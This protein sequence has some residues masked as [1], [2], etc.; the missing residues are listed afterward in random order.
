MAVPKDAIPSLAECQC[1]ICTEIF[2]EPVTLP[3]NHTLCNPCFQSTVEKANLCCPFCRRRVSSWTRYHTRRKTLVNMELWETIQKHYPK[4]CKLRACGQESEEIVDDFQPVRV[5]SIPGELRR[6]YEEE[7][8]K[9]EAER[10]ANEEKE[11][12]ASEEYIQR[13]LAEEE[14]EEKRQAEKRQREME[15]QLKSDEELARRLSINISSVCERSVVASPLNSRKSNSVTVKSQK[16]SKNF[17]K[18]TGDIQKYLSPKSLF[19]SASQSEDKQSSISKEN[20]SGD[21]ASPL[22]P[23]TEIEE[24][25]PTLSPQI[26]PDIEE[27]DAASL[28]E[29][30]M[31]QLS[32][33]GSEWSTEGEVKTAL[34]NH[35]KELCV[36]NPE[37]PQTK[38]FRKT[39]VNHCGRTQSGLS[40]VTD[41]VTTTNS[42]VEAKNEETSLLN[43]IDTSKRKNQEPSSETVKDPCISPKR[44]KVFPKIS[45]DQEEAEINFTQKLIE[46]EQLLFERHKQE[47]QDRLLALQLQKEVDK[48]QMKPNRQKGS[49]DAYQLRTTTIYPD[50]LPNG[51]KNSK[52]KNF[53]KQ[54]DREHPQ[55]R[56]GSRDENCQP[57]LKHL[58]TFNGQ[59]KPNSTKDRCNARSLQSSNSQRSIFQMFQ[60]YRK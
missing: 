33:C 14:E 8:S 36:L 60:R 42:T 15:E 7:I 39:D 19:G 24:D 29:S 6:E 41:I 45:T 20:D 46:W 11:N 54:T 21:L 22:W 1:Q 37:D 4:E 18:N 58:D 26:S 17:P 53:Q 16:K 40:S 44:R 56:R 30:P 12:K 47:E 9:V 13:L 25:M 32:A 5:L 2:I 23:D 49:P 34:N 43:S 59:R 57:P 48:E 27:Q 35:D 50:K 52:D 55:M 10:R 31:P 38:L 3:C 28:V 51:Q